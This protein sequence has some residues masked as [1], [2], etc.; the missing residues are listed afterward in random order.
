MKF[1]KE[2][3]GESD[4]LDT[5]VYQLHNR[6]E[7]YYE[8][9]LELKNKITSNYFAYKDAA[10]SYYDKIKKEIKSDSMYYDGATLTLKEIQSNPQED[11]LQSETF[12][13]DEDDE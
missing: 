2:A 4:D 6:F 5:F 1:L 11:E 8:V 9:T 13:D 3:F 10:Q 12:Y 7:T